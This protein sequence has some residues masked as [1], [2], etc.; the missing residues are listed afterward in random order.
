MEFGKCCKSCLFYPP[1]SPFLGFTNTPLGLGL[2]DL[3]D[4]IQY[5]NWNFL[6]QLFFIIIHDLVTMFLSEKNDPTY[7][8]RYV[9][10]HRT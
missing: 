8:D 4:A 1:E 7:L 3:Y 9:L 2:N 6:L 10:N 5:G